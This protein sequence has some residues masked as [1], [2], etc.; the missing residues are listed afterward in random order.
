MPPLGQDG[1][2]L[3][4]PRSVPRPL[5]GSLAKHIVIQRTRM[6]T[7]RTPLLRQEGLHLWATVP[8]TYFMLHS[9]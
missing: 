8:C 3:P 7:L 4:V 6:V 1:P 9:L 2:H 5:T